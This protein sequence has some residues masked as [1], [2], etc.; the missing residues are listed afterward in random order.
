MLKKTRLQLTTTT[1]ATVEAEVQCDSHE[2]LDRQ[3]AVTAE[4]KPTPRGNWTVTSSRLSAEAQAWQPAPAAPA[5]QEFQACTHYCYQYLRGL[6]AEQ[7]HHQQRVDQLVVES[8]A[9]LQKP[10]SF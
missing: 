6:T 4:P 9:K 8:I 2:L 10:G 1:T 3:V 7:R 5:P